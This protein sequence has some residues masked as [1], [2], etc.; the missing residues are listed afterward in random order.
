MPSS[1]SVTD[2]RPAR[3]S[4]L[5]VY[6]DQQL[7]TSAAAFHGEIELAVCGIWRAPSAGL[8][9]QTD[10]SAATFRRIATHNSLSKHILSHFISESRQAGRCWRRRV[11]PSEI[12]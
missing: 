6:C 9:G 5:G 3:K 1:F 11:P 7:I 10:L 2:P 12:R 8:F 4:G